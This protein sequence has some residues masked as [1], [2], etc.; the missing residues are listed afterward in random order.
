MKDQIIGCVM[1]KLRNDL[2]DT[3]YAVIRKLLSQVPEDA[4]T[5]YLP[6]STMKTIIRDN[7]PAAAKIRQI[8]STKCLLT[9]EQYNEYFDLISLVSNYMKSFGVTWCN[10][11]SDLRHSGYGYRT[12]FT[13]IDSNGMHDI[14][15]KVQRM[16]PTGVT[17]KRVPYENT[18]R[19]NIVIHSR[20]YKHTHV[21]TTINF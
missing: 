20:N 6:T 2:R 18:L 3:N 10:R 13:L 4:L 12:K 7:E 1:S 19:T 16:L 11:Y 8:R 15:D 14:V 21:Q 9:P 17:V 5:S